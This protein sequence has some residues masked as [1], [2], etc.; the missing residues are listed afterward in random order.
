MSEFEIHLNRSW[1]VKRGLVVAPLLVIRNGLPSA[2]FQQEAV[3]VTESRV[4]FYLRT[5][6][7][8]SGSRPRLG[9]QARE[10]RLRKVA[11][12]VVS[13]TSAAQPRRRST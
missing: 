11:T 13:S 3:V 5:R 4:D 10:G 2:V 1:I 8:V 7:P 9:A 12:E 6:F